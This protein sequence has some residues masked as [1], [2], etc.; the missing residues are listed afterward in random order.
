MKKIKKTIKFIK[1]SFNKFISNLFELSG[2]VCRCFQKEQIK[3]VSNSW[4]GKVIDPPTGW[5]FGFPKLCEEHIYNGDLN[6]W[7]V[8]NGYPQR[9]IDEM[10][11]YFYVSVWNNEDDIK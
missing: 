2:S 6:A 5:A 11:S 8:R 7:L 10:G 9:L 3:D 4:F 1:V